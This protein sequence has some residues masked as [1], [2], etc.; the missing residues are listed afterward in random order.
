MS[1]ERLSGTLGF[2]S[3]R[4][5]RT[6][7]YLPLASVG[8]EGAW[9]GLCYGREGSAIPKKGLY[10]LRDDLIWEDGVQVQLRAVE[11]TLARA[12]YLRSNACSAECVTTGAEDGVL[13]ELEM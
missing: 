2:I 10:L 7:R 1:R 13:E 9:H 4:G 8:L 6:L 5:N 12:G 3:M 11:G